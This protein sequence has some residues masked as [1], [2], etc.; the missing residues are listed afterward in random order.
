[1]TKRKRKNKIKQF[2]KV[3]KRRI[4]RTNGNKILSWLGRNFIQHPFILGFLAF[5]WVNY[6][7]YK[8]NFTAHPLKILGFHIGLIII[9]LILVVFSNLLKDKPHVKWYFRKRFVFF[10][11]I[12][13]APLGLIFLWL[14]S[15]FKKVTK[16]VLT[17]I[18]I[19]LFLVSNF[20]QS[21]RQE[22]FAKG[23]S[24]D[25]I[26]KVISGAKRETFIKKL[27]N[28]DLNSLKLNKIPL[29]ERKKLA[30]SD[31]SLACTKGVVFI[32]TKDNLG[33]DLGMGSGMV[34]SSNGVILT[35][36]HV[37][38]SAYSAEIKFGENELKEAYLVG[39]FPAF[40]MALLKVDMENLT[41]LAIGNSDTVRSGQ[42]VFVL[43]SPAGLE[44]SISSGI[45]S[46]VRTG[47]RINLIQMT[48]PVSPGSSG[49][50]V[51][52]EF[53][54]VI[55][56]TTIGSFFFTQNLNFSI[57]INY[58]VKSIEKDSSP[59]TNPK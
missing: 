56:I 17:V 19:G 36:M 16:I 48:A 51:M 55:G 50:P 24:Y 29:R 34:L 3:S 6:I 44:Q 53:G 22:R 25:R 54:E 31:I 10:M 11:S 18:F 40:D 4:K 35:S 46:A 49:G 23:L 26:I 14:G 39:L 8:R 43:G 57:P 59:A 20:Y 30:A 28:F 52:N 37:L 33:R 47:G 2:V 45:V 13:F 27:D 41:P 32:K 1:M 9:W 5:I 42:F 12:F 38:T 15:N 21:K 7:F 58:F